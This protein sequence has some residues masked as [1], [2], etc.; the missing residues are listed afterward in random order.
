MINQLDVYINFSSKIKV[1]ILAQKDKKIYF[2]YDKKFL[3]LDL[4]ISP[5][6]LPLKAGVQRCD[7]D[8]FEGIWEYLMIV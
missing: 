5:Y 4:D 8:V 7:D 6:K 2:E 1:G 3:K